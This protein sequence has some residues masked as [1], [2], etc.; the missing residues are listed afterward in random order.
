MKKLLC[1]FLTLVMVFSLC[2]CSNGDSEKSTSGEETKN[3][4]S[5]NKT[6]DIGE[7]LG[8]SSGKITDKTYESELLG[9]SC[10]F[11]DG[12]EFYPQEK[13]L[14]LNNIDKSLIDDPDLIE[15]LKELNIVYD[16]FAYNPEGTSNVNVCFEKLSDNQISQLDIKTKQGNQIESLNSTYETIGYSDINITQNIIKVAE[17]EVNALELTAKLNDSD[18]YLTIFAFRRGG[19]LA[20]VSVSSYNAEKI[21][22]VIESFSIN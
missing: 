4:T 11:A 13:V 9:L 1:I 3:T 8:F 12:W 16:M 19:Y 6:F 15:K 21:T 17:K 2:A 22:E 7:N 14:E 20:N 5:Q 10:T 18:F